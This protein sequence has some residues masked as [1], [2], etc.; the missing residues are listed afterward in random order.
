F[1]LPDASPISEGGAGY[2]VR[3]DDLPLIRR[4]LYHC[5]NPACAALRVPAVPTVVRN[6]ACHG[7]FRPTERMRATS[8]AA[9]AD[10]T[11]ALSD[12]VG[13]NMGIETV[14]STRSATSRLRPPPSPPT[15][16][17][18]GSVRSSRP[19]RDRSAEASSPTVHRPRRESDAT[20]SAMEPTTATGGCPGPRAAAWP[21][22][23]RGGAAR[24][25][26]RTKPVMPAATAERTTA[27]TLWGST[28]RSSTITAAGWDVAA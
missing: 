23:P 14:T 27:P 22:P 4:L 25:S 9:R 1:F 10:A 18:T 26:E 16:M 15:T 6:G 17:A 3:T 8:K 2:R 11:E 12:S 24:R 5:A 20:A 19:H 21:P 13:P 7:P 28:S